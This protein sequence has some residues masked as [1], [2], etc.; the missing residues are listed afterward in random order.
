MM[1]HIVGMVTNVQIL[2]ACT[3]KILEGKHVKI[4][5]VFSQLSILTANVL[6]TDRGIKNRKQS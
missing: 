1:R 5:H 4:W 3:P 2:V 6:G